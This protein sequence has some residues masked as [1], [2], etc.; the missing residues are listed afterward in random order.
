MIMSIIRILELAP[1]L[2][3]FGVES[4]TRIL[5]SLKIVFLFLSLLTAGA[6]LARPSTAEEGVPPK[7]EFV[8]KGARIEFSITPEHS[9]QLREGEFATVAFRITDETTGNPIQALNPAAWIDLHGESSSAAKRDEQPLTCRDKVRLYLQGTVGYN[10]L[11]DLNS[12][13]ILAMN[14][15]KTISV[16]D[17]LK[18][19]TGITQLYTMIYLKDTAEDW[20]MSRDEKKL[21]ITMPRA[22]TVAV[23]SLETF[24]VI[25]NIEAGTRP[26]RASLQPD[27]K[28]LWV[29]NDALRE[30]ESGVTV[31][32]AEQLKV[33]ARIPTGAGHHEI[34]FSQDS[35]FAFVTNRDDGT[36]SIIDTQRLK[37][38]K[39]IKT[40]D[41]PS[42]ISFSGL[43]NA[44]Y[45]AHEGD[46][47]IISIDAAKREITGRIAAKP[48]FRAIRF[49]PG[50]RWGFAVNG[51]ESLVYVIDASNN[52]LR[53]TIGVG[54]DPDQVV[55][56]DS[57]AYVRPRQSTEIKAIALRDLDIKDRPVVVGSFGGGQKPPAASPHTSVADAISRSQEHN[58]ILIANPA[59]QVIYYY[60]EGMAASA[61]SFR[62]VGGAV[63][64]AVRIVN[65]VLRATEP[66]VYSAKVR[67][68]ASGKYDV[69][70]LMDSPQVV[71]C[72]EFTAKPNPVLARKDR[73]APAV[74]FITKEQTVAVGE[75][76]TL[77]FRAMDPLKKE[78]LT[79]IKDFVVQAMT[80]GGRF[81]RQVAAH[82]GEGVYEVSFV[83]TRPGAC[84]VTLSIP[85]MKI[86]S[87]KLPHLI[88]Q[89][90]KNDA[91][92]AK[93]RSMKRE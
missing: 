54:K 17:P 19:I 13:Y 30:D 9:K 55:F 47:M 36:L 85:S 28:Y 15:D 53:H 62:G 24:K 48:G 73:D 60:M 56:T 80:P 65:R 18:G 83:V 81:D 86:D 37:K 1:N 52:S 82:S 42:S 64:R 21:F 39:E 2:I 49:A 58:A 89:V 44:A 31:I 27:G 71:H 38:I 33:A 26:F 16:I 77:R 75:R 46:G 78:A 14:H 32:D 91:E 29:G 61:G 57:F 25:E 22:N 35:L 50:D 20:A 69:A 3:L 7:E 68:P 10:P 63:Q 66:G 93:S 72:F 5:L 11:L 70:F 34:A 45:V 88:L 92:K 84:Y 41:L 90:L 76:F 12:Y 8:Q 43:S 74:E 23:A 67:L 79:D 59:D 6:A 40:G 51:P 4:L 87:R